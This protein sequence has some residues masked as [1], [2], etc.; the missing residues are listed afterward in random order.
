M[1]LLRRITLI[2]PT[3]KSSKKSKRAPFL[4]VNTDRKN[5]KYINKLVKEIRKHHL[6]EA[7]FGI[8]LSYIQPLDIIIFGDAASSEDYDVRV[9]DDKDEVNELDGRK[10]KSSK[11]F[12]LVEDWDEVIRQLEK[13]A[14]NNYSY[15]RPRDLICC[16]VEERKQQQRR[17]RKNKKSHTIYAI[18]G[19]VDIIDTSLEE[20][21]REKKVTIFCNFV[22]IGYNM[23]DIYVDLCGNEFIFYGKRK[24]KL[25][26][27]TSIWGE[28]Y[29]DV[30]PA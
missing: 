14:N 30:V 21:W 15:T 6:D 10:F 18:S 4:V 2:S 16:T 17:E 7:D 9:T 29:L 23:Y 13:Y 27:N 28:K 3:S 24:T 1:T 20:E 8:D 22:K 26:V 11:T 12:D 25:F 19:N 5:G